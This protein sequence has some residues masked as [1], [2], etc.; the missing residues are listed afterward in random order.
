MR[1][2]YSNE[3]LVSSSPPS[4]WPREGDLRFM[5]EKV[6]CATLGLSGKGSFSL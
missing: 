5:V 3:S 2:A 1:E 6:D 4:F